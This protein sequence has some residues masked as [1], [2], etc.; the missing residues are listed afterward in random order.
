[1]FSCV[2]VTNGYNSVFI[3]LVITVANT[4][5]IEPIKKCVKELRFYKKEQILYI[6]TVKERF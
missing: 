4:I 3:D 1:M 2:C 6:N 5:N